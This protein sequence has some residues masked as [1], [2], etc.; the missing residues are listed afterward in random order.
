VA[1]LSAPQSTLLRLVAQAHSK[2]GRFWLPPSRPERVEDVDVRVNI[3]GSGCAAAHRALVRK[4]L[5]EPAGLVDYDAEL[6]SEGERAV[7][8]EL[9]RPVAWEHR[10]HIHPEDEE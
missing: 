10:V 6:T 8:A 1:K 3:S 2:P 9:G 7:Q 4:G 5:I